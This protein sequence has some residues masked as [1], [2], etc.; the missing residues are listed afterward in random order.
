MNSTLDEEDV[1][2]HNNEVNDG[3]SEP[4]EESNKSKKKQLQLRINADV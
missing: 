2:A 1:D 3:P 4:T